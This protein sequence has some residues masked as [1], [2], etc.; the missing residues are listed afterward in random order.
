M[1]WA[2]K[3]VQVLSVP[4]NTLNVWRSYE[5]VWK[6]LEYLKRAKMKIY[7][8]FVFLLFF[9]FFCFYMAEICRWNH[10]REQ[11]VVS[12]ACISEVTPSIVLW[13]SRFTAILFTTLFVHTKPLVIL[14]VCCLRTK[15][16]APYRKW[17]FKEVKRQGNSSVVFS[18]IA[19]QDAIERE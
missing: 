12:P 4:L 9:F 14:I 18:H 11:L 3:P 13:Y 19:H 7:S 6:G 1:H 15:N 5:C 10:M 2:L 16:T 17:S 8:E